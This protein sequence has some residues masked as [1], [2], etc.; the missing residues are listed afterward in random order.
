MRDEKMRYDAHNRKFYYHSSNSYK[1]SSADNFRT[2]AHAIF[3]VV[4]IVI[5]V[6]MFD[7]LFINYTY[8]NDMNRMKEYYAPMNKITQRELKAR[9]ERKLS[10]EDEL[11]I[12]EQ[13][14]INKE[15]EETPRIHIYKLNENDNKRKSS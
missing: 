11:E 2:P 12:D 13:I 10:R 1:T 5:T 3:G 4:C 6:F 14:R 9:A 15:Y 8:Q 7:A